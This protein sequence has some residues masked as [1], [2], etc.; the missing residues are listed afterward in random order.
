MTQLQPFLWDGNRLILN[1]RLQPRAS[2]DEVVGVQSD[3]RIKIR[4]TAPPVDGAANEHLQRFLA[5]ICKVKRADVTLLSGL[6]GRNKRIAI[7]GPKDL[8]S[9]LKITK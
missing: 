6:T 4:I 7:C 9:I 8:P 2:R 1:I 3:G 5:T